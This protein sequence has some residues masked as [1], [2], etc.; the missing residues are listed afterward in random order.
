MY[1]ML[2]DEPPQHE[3]N[4]ASGDVALAVAYERI[5]GLEEQ[6][7]FLQEQLGLEQQRN[8]ELVSELKL[9]SVPEQGRA[10]W[11]LWWRGRGE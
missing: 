1:V 8:A 6:L 3:D 7:D 11:R 9:V 4:V 5:R 2:D 10:W